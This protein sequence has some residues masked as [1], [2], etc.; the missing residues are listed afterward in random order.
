MR[1]MYDKRYLREISGG[2]QSLVYLLSDSF[3]VKRHALLGFL[4]KMTC[5]G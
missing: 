4:F 1:D 5:Q 2:R 3:P